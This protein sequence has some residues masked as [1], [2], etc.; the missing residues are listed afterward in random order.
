VTDAAHGSEAGEPGSKRRLT[1]AGIVYLAAIGLAVVLAVLGDR[2]EK[3]ISVLGGRVPFA[4]VLF[5]LVLMGVALFHHHTLKVALG[6]VTAVT[7]YT[8]I[9]VS[10]VDLGHHFLEEGNHTLL[11]LGGLLLGFALL[12]K[13]FEHS[14][15]PDHLP[16]L[17][18]KAPLWSAFVLL[19]VVWI[20]SSFLDN[21]AAAM[22]GGVI[23]KTAFRGR[24]TV[25]YIAAIVAASNAG[26]AWSV[27]GDTTTT[28]M[29]IAGVSALD[30]LHAVVA[31]AVALLCLGFFAASA[32][33]KVQ[34]IH[35]DPAGERKPI[36]W[37]QI[38][39]VALIL[40]GAI[41][42][43]IK[44]DRPYV[45]VWVAILL[46]SLLRK[47]AWEEIPGAAK[48]ALF[49]LS[50][51][52]CASLMPVEALPEASW[53][54]AF[55]LGFVSAVFDNIPLTKLAIDQGGYDWGMLAY[56]VGF[57]GSMVWFG[58]SA[59]V[60][61]SKDFPEARN[62]GR[63]VREGWP[64]VLAYVLGFFAML[65]ALGWQPHARATDGAAPP[66]PVP[67]ERPAGG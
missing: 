33:N 61:I 5:V 48:G 21:I 11:N 15:A 13:Y 25:G 38:L 54:T 50:L 34:T 65:L 4:F 42:T 55:G 35:V 3:G 12:A 58:S 45:G 14:G 17:L 62:A 47:A 52:W 24:V 26:G 63:Y 8:A 67:V 43:N 59:G 32:Q 18:P 57:G 51:V 20:L 41:T 16:R 19:A 40:A 27:V 66:A 64:V 10:G 30:V 60:A 56:C 7:L 22:I 23:A 31:S 37:V 9:F 28:M 29:W 1:T 39:I 6:G 36:D 44:L 2:T 46:G 53:Q 49:L